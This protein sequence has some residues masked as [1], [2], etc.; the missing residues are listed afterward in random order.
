MHWRVLATFVGCV[1]GGVWVEYIMVVVVVVDGDCAGGMLGPK[2]PAL[3]L[4][5]PSFTAW[6]SVRSYSQRP[7]ILF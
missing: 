6:A 2:N 7:F 1:L 5:N 3:G 4:P